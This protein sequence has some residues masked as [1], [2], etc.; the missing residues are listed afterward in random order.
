M[1]CAILKN[2]IF[3]SFFL[4]VSLSQI[5]G[6]RAACDAPLLIESDLVK[7]IL[8]PAKV[9]PF[10]KLQES[11]APSLVTEALQYLEAKISLIVEDNSAPT[12]QNTYA[13]LDS[14]FTDMATFE[15]LFGSVFYSLMMSPVTEQAYAKFGEEKLR[16]ESKYLLNKNLWERM[17]KAKQVSGT[18]AQQ[19]VEKKLIEFIDKKFLQEGIELS[20]ANKQRLEKNKIESLRQQTAFN[21][22]VVGETSKIRIII[23]DKKRLAGL[24][25]SL[26]SEAFERAQKEGISGAYSFA[27]S[28]STY[29]TIIGSA[30]DRDLRKEIFTKARRVSPNIGAYSTETTLLSDE[31]TSESLKAVRA[32]AK[33]RDEKA[34]ILGFENYASWVAASQSAASL[35]KVEDFLKELLKRSRV[36]AEV[37]WK[38]LSQLAA[39]DG[40]K[41]LQAWDVMFYRNLALS[42]F[43]QMDTSKLNSYFDLNSVISRV[44]KN[45]NTSFG[46]EFIPDES[47]ELYNSQDVKAYKVVDHRR[48][49]EVAAYVYLDLY[50]R[51]SKGGAFISTVKRRRVSGNQNSPASVVV[52]YNFSRASKDESNFISFEQLRTLLHELGHVCHAVKSDTVFG[53]LASPD[54]VAWDFVEFPSKLFENF[55]TDPDFMNQVAYLNGDPAQR[56]PKEVLQRL[57]L[58]QNFMPG[59]LYLSKA[60]YSLIDLAWHS[61]APEDNVSVQ[62]FEREVIGGT[63]MHTPF[64]NSTFSSTFTH[65]FSSSEYAALFYSY[66][67]SQAYADIAYDLRFAKEGALNPKVGADMGDDILK[68]GAL[69]P[70]REQFEKFSGRLFDVETFFKRIGL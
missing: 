20:D 39:A 33:L 4:L 32:L 69:I 51:A 42:R 52:S 30:S 10:A 62:D 34:K 56:L 18:T 60:I 70:E 57:A 50:G 19:S 21:D 45:I 6:A 53:T 37:E 66:L 59:V 9:L 36:K 40:V 43:L 61:K 31:A 38:E 14:L 48:S 24:P 54:A 11:Q 47:L 27:I 1:L 58:S 68:Q 65:I 29:I 46:L 2:F 8:H 55:I 26:I 41:E 23:K 16:L 17:Q 22:A 63:L 67:Y 28:G 7:E 12:F 35:A 5:Q 3:L 64:E 49:G 15:S 25:D 44:L 13:A